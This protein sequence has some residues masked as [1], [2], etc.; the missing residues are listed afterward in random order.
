[1]KLIS[2]FFTL[3]TLEID[4]LYFPDVKYYRDN[5]NTT[6]IHYAIECFSNGVLT[7]DK[8]IHTLAKNT[9]DTKKNIHNIVSKY[10]EDFEGFEY[11]LK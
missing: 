2:E 7:Y 8:L 5:K 1:M 4:K 11:I 3:L 6:N 10:I 9:K